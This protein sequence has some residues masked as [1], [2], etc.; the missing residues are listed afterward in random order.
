VSDSPWC[1]STPLIVP[2]WAAS[3]PTVGSTSAWSTAWSSPC[4]SSANPAMLDCPM[5][6]KT[7][8]SSFSSGMPQGS[9]AEGAQAVMKRRT[10]MVRSRV[11]FLIRPRVL[12]LPRGSGGRTTA[13]HGRSQV[14]P[15]STSFCKSRWTRKWGEEPCRVLAREDIPSEA[16]EVVSSRRW[17][18]ARRRRLRCRSGSPPH[19]R[20]AK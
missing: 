1:Q 13:P 17:R 14:S 4:S 8:K 12:Y 20:S 18:P 6:R 10:A 15:K 16:G 5:R 11:G 19:D 7:W 9:S 3:S 2:R